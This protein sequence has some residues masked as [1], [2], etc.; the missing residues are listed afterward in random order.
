[1]HLSSAQR[2]VLARGVTPVAHTAAGQLITNVDLS[3]PGLP[4]IT[5]CVEKLLGFTIGVSVPATSF[6][7]R[8]KLTSPTGL[9]VVTRSQS[10]SAITI[11]VYWEIL[12]ALGK[13]QRGTVNAT[14]ATN[15]VTT[16]V[17]ID[18]VNLNTAAAFQNGYEVNAATY[19]CGCALQL[20]GATTLEVH[21]SMYG[22]NTLTSNWAVDGG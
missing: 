5:R 8:I 16:N 1:M 10:G 7:A 11:T 14:V 9:E 4:P 2:K 13:V 3:T 6:Y 21:S 12:K 17:A 19:F 22:N 20:T 15:T 18:P